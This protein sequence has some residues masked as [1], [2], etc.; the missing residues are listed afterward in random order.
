MRPFLLFQILLILTGTFACQSSNPEQITR[1]YLTALKAKNWE[2]AKSYATDE[3]KKNIDALE[4]SNEDVRIVEINDI[5]C[6]ETDTIATCTFCC[7]QIHEKSIVKLKK[8]NGK[9][10]VLGV[11][12]TN[13]TF[14]ESPS[15]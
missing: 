15:K 8:I 13:S 10:K 2:K 5:E 6:K 3:C 7:V 12:E 1:E 9:W 11:K 4:R 14:T